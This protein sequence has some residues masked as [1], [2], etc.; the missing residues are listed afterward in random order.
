[1]NVRRAPQGAAGSLPV[2]P[3]TTTP[4]GRRPSRRWEAEG[5]PRYRAR[6]WMRA[7]DGDG[8]TT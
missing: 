4:R 5:D 6:G 7:N 1:M 3:R 2:L 8:R